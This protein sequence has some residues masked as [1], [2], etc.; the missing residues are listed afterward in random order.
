MKSKPKFVILIVLYSLIFLVVGYLAGV[1]ISN[2][3]NYK[4]QDVMF[5][6]GL[7]VVIIG[8]L[9]SMKGNPSGIS[10][11][12]LGQN[13]AQYRANEN[14][15]VIVRERESTNYYKNFFKHS[16]VELAFS[17]IT[18]IIGGALIILFSAIYG[19]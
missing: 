9:F 1:V 12:G 8:A 16:V 10:L 14:L 4:L 7:I 11:Q 6:E 19:R 5:I 13:D 2:G 3:F 18:I 15:E 17:N